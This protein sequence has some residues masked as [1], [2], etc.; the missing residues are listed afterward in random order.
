MTAQ[1]DNDAQQRYQWRLY[2]ATTAGIA[3]FAGMLANNWLQ[4]HVRFGA[5]T[6][7]KYTADPT[8]TRPTLSHPR[9]ARRPR[10]RPERT[11]HR[12][13]CILRRVES[14]DPRPRRAALVVLEHEP[15]PHLWTM[16]M[17]RDLAARRAPGRVPHDAMID[18]RTLVPRLACDENRPCSSLAP[19][20]CRR[21][22]AVGR[23]HKG[24]S[25]SARH[26]RRGS[27]QSALNR[28]CPVHRARSRHARTPR[29]SVAAGSGAPGRP[30]TPL[31][32]ANPAA[33]CD[34]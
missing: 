21:P 18:H 16:M 8:T 10:A 20:S 5:P 13:P 12:L 26:G 24:R 17:A 34:P 11:T 2:T 7:S 31:G 15:H 28:P 4:R 14:A 6:L 22:T 33:P 27:S 9:E 23:E 30:P 19:P 29:P 3:F 32:L 1:R 25:A